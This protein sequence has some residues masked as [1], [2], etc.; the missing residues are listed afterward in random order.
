MHHGHHHNKTNNIGLI[1]YLT[2]L[3]DAPYYIGKISSP[4]GFVMLILFLIFFVVLPVG[5]YFGMKKL[6]ENKNERK[7]EKQE[8]R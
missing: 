8:R 6:F 2:N 1:L 7:Q 5:I 4:H 3:L